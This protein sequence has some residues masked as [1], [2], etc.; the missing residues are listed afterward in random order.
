M[1]SDK[2][3]VRLSSYCLELCSGTSR[4]IL[5][6]VAIREVLAHLKFDSFNQF[7]SQGVKFCKWFLFAAAKR[8]FLCD[9]KHF[10]S[11]HSAI[12]VLECRHAGR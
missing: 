3:P 9:Q 12:F 8:P 1:T 6:D 11:Y 4:I 5:R 7:S 10:E 2:S